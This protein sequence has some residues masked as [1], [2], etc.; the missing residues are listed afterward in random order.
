MPNLNLQNRSNQQLMVM[1]HNIMQ[2]QDRTAAETRKKVLY[3]ELANRNRAFCSGQ[4]I[5]VMPSDGALSAFGYHVG[6]EKRK[7]ILKCVLEAP[8]PPVVNRDYTQSWGLPNSVSR[9]EKLLRTLKGLA[10]GV[11]NRGAYAHD[12][13]ARA[14]SHWEQDIEYVQGLI[15]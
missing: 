8:I 4:D 1:L 13:Y 10:S 12:S 7:L 2:H 11:K 3:Q 6:A 5:D 15:V 9:K 14:L